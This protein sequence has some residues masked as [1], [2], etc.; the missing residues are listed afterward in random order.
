MGK[1]RKK[2]RQREGGGRRKETPGAADSKRGPNSQEG[3]EKQNTLNHPRFTL[4][5]GQPDKRARRFF[6]SALAASECETSGKSSGLKNPASR[7]TANWASA[8]WAQLWALAVGTE[9][10]P[11][12]A[13]APRETGR[14]EPEGNL[15]N[16]FRTLRGA[17]TSG[18]AAT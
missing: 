4:R 2:R 16:D 11:P 6:S 8:D 15:L 18:G 10:R 7:A 9:G 1:C 3:W 14:D 13:P 12:V 17:R 5:F